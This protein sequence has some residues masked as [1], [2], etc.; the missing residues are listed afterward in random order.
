MEASLT[1]LYSKLLDKSIDSK[2]LGY[3]TTAIKKGNVTLHDFKTSIMRSDEYTSRVASLFKQQY[4]EMVGFEGVMDELDAYEAQRNKDEPVTFESIGK[5]IKDTDAYARKIHSMIQATYASVAQGAVAPADV[6]NEYASRFR[7]D[8]KYELD[9]LV[10]DLQ[11]TMHMMNCKNVDTCNDHVDNT[12]VNN[13]YFDEQLPHSPIVITRQPVL[14]VSRLHEFEDVFG[15]P[16]FV[17]EYFKYVVDSTHDVF[18]DLGGLKTK[19]ESVYNSARTLHK[20]YTGGDL[21]E[22]RF[23]DKY[24]D[25]IDDAS[26]LDDFVNDIVASESYRAAMSEMINV[27][28]NKL[29]DTTL[30][31][32]DIRHLFERVRARKVHLFDDALMEA[33]KSFN[34]ET[35]TYIENLMAIF[36][37][38]LGREPELQE[39]GAFVERYRVEAVGVGIDGVNRL[40][41]NKLIQS[42]EFHDVVKNMIK[43][44]ATGS[45]TN[46]KLYEVLNQV[47]KRI[48][49]NTTLDEIKTAIRALVA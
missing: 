38:V 28:N 36:D 22:W 49:D 3:W 11:A 25:N 10:R 34:A 6:V 45:I 18:A 44:Q 17:K 47:I 35:E 8:N 9:D 27:W 40:V 15:R 16:M 4:F 20:N 30:D 19:Y 1:E 13:P 5:Y 33:V 26:F 24:L 12:H 29:Y 39:I 23:V 37:Q 42:L 43:T 41:A 32:N 7:K 14:D 46:S 21:V 31:D 48:G 2:T